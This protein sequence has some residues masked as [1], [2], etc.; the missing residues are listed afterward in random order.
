MPNALLKI[1][2]YLPLT[3]FERLIVCDGEIVEYVPRADRE[4]EVIALVGPNFS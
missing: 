1:S 4:A 2:D 3:L